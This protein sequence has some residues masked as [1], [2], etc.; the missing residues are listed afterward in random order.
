MP[1]NPVTGA[2]PVAVP[3][4]VSE[5]WPLTVNRAPGKDVTY[6]FCTL[7]VLASEVNASTWLLP[8]E[9]AGKNSPCGR[10]AVSPAAAVLLVSWTGVPPLT[11]MAQMWNRVPAAP[12]DVRL[13]EKISMVSSAVH[14]GVKFVG[15]RDCPEASAKAGGGLKTSNVCTASST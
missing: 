9:R 13:D 2:P 6:R 12:V 14:T 15:V 10:P 7:G 11:G 1:L 3:W 8:E 5:G 4:L